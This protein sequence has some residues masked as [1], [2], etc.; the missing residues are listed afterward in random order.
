MYFRKILNPDKP[1]EIALIGDSHSVHL[2]SGLAEMDTVVDRNI[3]SRNGD[4]CL[5][6]FELEVAGR[7]YNAE[8]HR[9][10]K[11]AQEAFP[12]VEFINLY[13]T[14]CDQDLCYAQKGGVLLYMDHS[15]LSAD[16]SRY[17]FSKIEDVL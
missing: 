5:P 11:S 7:C 4:G 8:Y 14:L 17:V 2:A 3:I 1:A 15:H 6:V 16:G 10:I 13:D 9:I 12:T